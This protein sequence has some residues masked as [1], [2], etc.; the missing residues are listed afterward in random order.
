MSHPAATALPWSSVTAAAR[1]RAGSDASSGRAEAPGGAAAFAAELTAAGLAGRALASADAAASPA[2]AAAPFTGDTRSAAGGQADTVDQKKRS[3][4]GQ[5]PKGVRQLD[6]GSVSSPNAPL[7]D[8]A[9]KPAVTPELADVPAAA[10]V[11]AGVAADVAAGAAND[12]ADTTTDPEAADPIATAAA[13][14]AGAS[15]E[16]AGWWA[17]SA[18]WARNEAALAQHAVGAAAAPG[19]SA[20]A[21]SDAPAAQ[22]EAGTTA[23]TRNATGHIASAA[24][25]HDLPAVPRAAGAGHPG[26]S[27]T[28]AGA[29][30]QDQA[31]A[32]VDPAAG[33][34]QTSLQGG[35]G[36]PRDA[37]GA[38]ARGA[39]A[40]ALPSALASRAVS[41]GKVAKTEDDRA[42]LAPQSGIVAGAGDAAATAAKAPVRGTVVPPDTGRKNAPA[43]L[44]SPDPGPV[45]APPVQA[46]DGPAFPTTAAAAPHGAP[47]TTGPA[48]PNRRTLADRAGG[49]GRNEPTVAV[50]TSANLAPRS[51]S[52]TSGAPAAPVAGNFVLAM[53]PAAEAVSAPPPG[54]EAR[55]PMPPGD[56]RFAPALAQQVTVFMRQGVHEARLELHPA[57]LGP[58]T[59]QIQL[60]GSAAQ[61]SMAASHAQTRQ[62]L[63]QALPT[64]AATL[65]EAGLTLTGGG[66]FEQPRPGQGDTPG[67]T[68]GGDGSRDRGGQ[69]RGGGGGDDRAG[70]E[71]AARGP[72]PVSVRGLVD[73]VA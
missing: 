66:V 12:L 1:H 55:L 59:V 35:A 5:W 45:T 20:A 30:R 24:P 23:I 33:T 44:A 62:A 19:A 51:T 17:Q 13:M 22:A 49:P 58:I 14:A 48:I 47:G 61:V 60:D 29:T 71:A 34:P 56:P 68:A 10:G 63:E 6:G 25:S 15:T 70:T 36:Q 57:E 8:G 18:A 3:R 38:T 50:D 28:P 53:P 69:A 9:T 46:Y 52:A 43:V 2:G 72:R 65:R 21:T 31:L 40:S 64:L 26:F 11:A 27:T 16:M 67:N 54:A 32:P 42:V 41:A 7:R 73:L 4:P 37:T 39:S